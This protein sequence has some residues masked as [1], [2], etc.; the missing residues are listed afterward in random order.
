MSARQLWG[1]PSRS[2][3]RDTH[4]LWPRSSSVRQET[5]G[6]GHSPP[7]PQASRTGAQP[8]GRPPRRLRALLVCGARRECKA[9]RLFPGGGP[10]ARL[11]L[12]VAVGQRRGAGP[13]PAASLRPVPS[14]ARAPMWLLGCLPSPGITWQH[15]R[16]GWSLF[17]CHGDFQCFRATDRPVAEWTG[18]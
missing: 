2:S 16:G 15:C 9:C 17:S 12:D 7:C 6:A 8:G 1:A 5:P 18:P 3:P 11:R 4:T 13:G 14:R 10:V